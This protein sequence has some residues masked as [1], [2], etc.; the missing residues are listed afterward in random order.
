VKR[1]KHCIILFFL[2]VVFLLIYQPVYSQTALNE[3]SFLTDYTGFGAR[4][5][6]MG[7][8]YTSIGGNYSSVYWNPSG[9]GLVK[10]QELYMS[11]LQMNTKNSASFYGNDLESSKN[12]TKL[13]ALGYVFPVPTYKGSLVFAV[14]YNRT[15]KFGNS[16]SLQGRNPKIALA[17][18]IYEDLEVYDDLYV[19]ETLDETGHIGQYSFSGA[20]E[21]QKDLFIGATLN[22]YHGYNEYNVIYKEFDDKNLYSNEDN[23]GFDQYN[24]TQYIK[25]DI[26]G[27]ELRVGAL[28]KLNENIYTG[29]TIIFP[30]TYRI[31]ENWK[32]DDIIYFDDNYYETYDD[33]SQYKY[34][35]QYPFRF[36]FGGSISTTNFLISGDIEYTDLSQMKYKNEPPVADISKEEANL[37]IRE[38]V[39]SILTKRV[40][41]EFLIPKTNYRIRG[42]YFV[43]PSPYKNVSDDKDKKGVSAGIGMVINDKTIIDIAYVRTWWN[44]KNYDGFVGADIDEQHKRNYIY[45]TIIYRF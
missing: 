4:A 1:I 25:S 31:E 7:G 19:K 35:V 23:T 32:M 24:Q 37:N 5:L 29:A 21:A 13:D 11:F 9:L 8:A 16:I 10:R 34:K 43:I 12:Q 38:Q 22:I 6:G 41:A 39:G 30:K 17:Y 18:Y 33:L 28:Y 2:L 40:G 26:S 36:S 20:V 45:A 44:E 42:G 27:Y 3:I 15:Q 14:G